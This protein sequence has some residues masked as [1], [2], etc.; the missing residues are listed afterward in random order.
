[1]KSTTEQEQEEEHLGKNEAKVQFYVQLFFYIHFRM[2]WIGRRWVKIK[3]HAYIYSVFFSLS[4]AII[5]GCRWYVCY[6]CYS[7]L[8]IIDWLVKYLWSHCTY[9]Y[10]YRTRKKWKEREHTHTAIISKH[11]STF[12]DGTKQWSIDAYCFL[13]CRCCC[14]FHSLSLF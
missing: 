9:D 1:M 2:I 4:L 11:L 12:I 7:S 10:I 14:F 8:W 3:I 5:V 13:C 6:V